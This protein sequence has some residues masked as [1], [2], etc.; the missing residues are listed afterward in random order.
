VL[1]RTG[2]A[3]ARHIDVYMGNDVEAARAFG[4]K[5]LRIEWTPASAASP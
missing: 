5:R 2:G 4:R 3:L 1:D